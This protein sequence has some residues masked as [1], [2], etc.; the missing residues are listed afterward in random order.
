MRHT[1]AS[2]RWCNSVLHRI[3]V[4]A[5]A[6]TTGSRQRQLVELSCCGRRC[7]AGLEHSHR[8]TVPSPPRRLVGSRH[9]RR[10]HVEQ[11][12]CCVAVGCRCLQLLLPLCDTTATFALQILLP[13]FCSVGPGGCR[14]A[15]LASCRLLAFPT[16]QFVG[17]EHD[18][19]GGLR[20]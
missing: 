4:W 9:I 6:A 5:A 13:W 18:C 7:L 20:L 12:P 1:T 10:L 11:A 14:A 2:G 15:I 16:R 3:D 19:V 8:A 17:T